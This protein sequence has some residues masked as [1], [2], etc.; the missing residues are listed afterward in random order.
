MRVRT[1]VCRQRCRGGA[2]VGGDGHGWSGARL[3][4][5]A[6]QGG[7]AGG[8]L[9]A[10]QGRKERE[11]LFSVVLLLFLDTLLLLLKPALL[12]WIA[13]IAVYTF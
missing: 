13:T 8:V 9:L 5:A 10:A 11:L 4:G 7:Q 6:A 2:L 1:S 12:R 3:E